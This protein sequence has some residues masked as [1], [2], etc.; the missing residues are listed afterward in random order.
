MS[1]RDFS[2]LVLICLAWGLNNVVSKIVVSHW[3]FPPFA[4]VAARFMLVFLIAFPWLLPAP[5][6]RWRMVAVGLLMGGAGFAFLSLG[7]QTA[8]PSAAAIVMQINV[9]LTTLLSVVMLGERVSWTRGIGILL[10]MAGAF[11]VIWQP[12]GLE[13]SP[14]LL[15]VAAGAAAGSL[16]AILMKQMVNVRPMQFQAWVAFSSLFPL[17]A[18]SALFETGQLAT[19][20]EAGWGLLAAIC[21]SALVGSVAAHTAYYGLIQR[22][23]ANLLAPLTLMTPLATIGLGVVITGD[24]FDF[25]MAAGAV[26]AM[27]GVLIVALR[28]NHVAPLALLVRQRA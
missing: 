1:A 17:A 10:T 26:L 11:L 19:A 5:R 12:G 7:L 13:L 23:E 16:G 4:F 14:G 8:S 28:P 3:D 27:L 20:L 15:L 24:A 9:P 25:R 2:I 18:A 6:P 22:Y 21:F